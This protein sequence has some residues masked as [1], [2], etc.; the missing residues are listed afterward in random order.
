M[1]CTKCGNKL[2][3]TTHLCPNCGVKKVVPPQPTPVQPPVQPPI[4][5]KVQPPV[6]PKVQPPV[7]PKV[8]P[9]VQP[10]QATPV[11]TPA[12]AGKTMP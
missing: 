1:F 3:E 12:E 9:P 7:Q 11:A 5:P 10:A 2:D 4:Q 8:Q 6:Q